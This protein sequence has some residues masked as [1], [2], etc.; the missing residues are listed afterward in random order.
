[1]NP[2]RRTLNNIGGSPGDVVPVDQITFNFAKIEITYAPQKSDGT[3][4]SPVVHHYSL[5]ENKGG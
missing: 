1:M 2:A 3:L 4:D 5:K